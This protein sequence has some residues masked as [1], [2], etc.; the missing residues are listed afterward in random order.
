MATKYKP[1]KKYHEKN[2]VSYQM[3]C[4]HPTEADIINEMDNQPNKARYL[5][6]LVREKIKKT[7]KKSPPN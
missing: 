1:Q 2:R 3:N 4:F 7:I 6:N 5:K